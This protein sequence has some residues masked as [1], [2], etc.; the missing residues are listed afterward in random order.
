MKAGVALN[1]VGLDISTK[2]GF[3]KLDADG[4]IIGAC[5]SILSSQDPI[6]MMKYI[7]ENASRTKIHTDDIVVLEGF[8]YASKQ[9]FLLGGI[10]WGIR[11]KLK[12]MGIDYI[13]VAPT[14]LKK[15]ATGSGVA[16]KRKLAV[17]VNKRWGFY[18]DSDNVTD[19]YVLAQIG[20]AIDSK[21]PV[22]KFQQEIIQKVMK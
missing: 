18:H 4:E 2:T 20:R 12:E 10:G 1:Y 8:G 16:D 21:C 14:Q 13:E 15:F 9:G 19:A 5:E 7:E 22:T 3:V 11:M 6:S 17:E